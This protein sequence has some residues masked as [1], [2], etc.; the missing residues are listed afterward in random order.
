MKPHNT[1]VITFV[2]NTD[3]RTSHANGDRLLRGKKCTFS[4]VGA[5]IDWSLESSRLCFC[6]NFDDK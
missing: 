5:E 2:V 6:D 4:R 1:G 3:E